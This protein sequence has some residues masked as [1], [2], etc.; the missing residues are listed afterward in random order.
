VYGVI[1]TAVQ[2]FDSNTT[3]DHT[4]N[5]DN[6]FSTSR[7]GFR[8]TENLGSGLKAE[9]QLEGRLRPSAGTYGGST[10]NQAFS[11]EAWVGL[12]GGF[13]QIRTGLT[14]LS[15]QQN[16]DGLA[17]P[18]AGNF[19]DIPVNGTS[20]EIGSDTTN[21]VRYISPVIGGLQVEVGHSTG[22]G[23]DSI[24]DA[25]ASINSV[26]AIYRSGNFRAGVG[27][28]RLTGAADVAKRDGT[29]YAVGYNFGFANAG[30]AYYK[31]DNSATAS[32]DSKAMV[33]SLAV[34]LSNSVEA[35]AI[36]GTSENGSQATD[37]K[38][39]GYTL[40]LTKDL[41][42]RTK[43]Y[44]H[45]TSVTNDANSSMTMT[46]TTAPGSAGGDTKSYGVGI[47]HVF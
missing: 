34:P 1:D 35:H 18:R 38:G 12:S 47:S 13:G 43:I 9:F 21:A 42:K 46:G 36:Y 10:T 20:L 27:Q 17:A 23:A 19:G 22:N 32:V 16:M 33:A 44:T 31:G 29:S 40:A 15:Q 6:L 24:T 37:N 2:K 45:Y 8:G 7:L 41:S 4:R 25:N 26:S 28:S 39:K 11:R 5:Q 14:D 3:T 30:V